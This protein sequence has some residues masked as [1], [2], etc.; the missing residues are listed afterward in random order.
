MQTIFS[1]IFIYGSTIKA[2]T[3][4][5]ALS[6]STVSRLVCMTE[7]RITHNMQAIQEFHRRFK[8]LCPQK[9]AI[10]YL[11]ETYFRIN[12]RTFL[13]ILVCDATGKILAWKLSKKR[14]SKILAEILEQSRIQHCNWSVLITDGAPVYQAAFRRLGI[15]GVLCNKFIAVRGRMLS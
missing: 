8:R 10:I 9:Q 1:L 4:R 14:S 13:L 11:D 3:E 7:K 15:A 6:R 12:G 5:F 2:I